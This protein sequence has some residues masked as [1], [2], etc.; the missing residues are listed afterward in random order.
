[1]TLLGL[2]ILQNHAPSNLNRDENGDPKDALFGGYRRARISSQALKR[3]FRWDDTFRRTITAMDDSLL[4]DRTRLLPEWVRL[5]VIDLGASEKE[6]QAIIEKVRRFGKSEKNSTK[7]SDSDDSPGIR[8]EQ[9]MFLSPREIDTLSRWL[10]Q[11]YR[12]SGDQFEAVT[13]KDMEQVIGAPHAVDIAMFGRMTT[14]SPFKDIEASIQVAH[15]LSTHAIE[16]EFDFFIGMDDRSNNPG[17]G[18]MGEV[19]FN[20][21][22]Y[23]KYI[24]IHWDG[25]LANLHGEVH[26]ARKALLAFLQ[27][28]I[29]VSPKG[30]QNTFAAH[31]MPDFVLVDVIEANIPLS[32]ANAFLKPV[33][34]REK[35]IMRGSIDALTEYAGD[36]RRKYDLAIDQAVFS[37]APIQMEHAYTCD[38]IRDLYAWVDARIPQQ[39]G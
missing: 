26:V 32:Y 34:P 29:T 2:H 35:P 19:A 4:A 17:A 38:T 39:E 20:S 25:L 33:V 28:A 27:A 1:M 3:S 36:I 16:P 6:E 8:T 23:Y 21:A 18:M 7:T 31:N 22:T 11:T 12:E 15:A 14:S 10:L 5:R 37:I 30:K 9:L 13:L 24:N